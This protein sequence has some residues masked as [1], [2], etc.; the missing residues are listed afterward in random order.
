MVNEKTWDSRD[1][2][3]F[4]SKLDS[5]G[6]IMVPKV[7]RLKHS[8]G[9]GSVISVHVAQVAQRKSERLLTARPQV[10]VLPWAP[11]LKKQGIQIGDD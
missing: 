2:C 6:R 1:L 7:V 5:K 4:T 11:K 3:S 8:L 10:R 9:S